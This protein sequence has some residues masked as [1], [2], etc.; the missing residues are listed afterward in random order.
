[1][2]VFNGHVQLHRNEGAKTCRIE[3]TSHPDDSFLRKA[4]YAKCSLHHRVERIADDDDD[5]VRRILDDLFG[6]TFDDF[7]ISAK[8]I[9]AAHSRFAWNSRSDHND[10]GV[11]RIL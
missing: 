7:V 3:N 5:T 10:V 2:D 6:D 11:R 9:V 4:A 1:M 8:K